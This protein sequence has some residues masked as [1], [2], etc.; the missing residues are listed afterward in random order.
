MTKT[1]NWVRLGQARH[2]RDGAGHPRGISSARRC[3]GRAARGRADRRRRRDKAIDAAVAAVAAR[4]GIAV[5]AL[6]GGAG[7]G[8]VDSAAL[9][10][11]AAKVTGRDGRAGVGGSMVL[12]QLGID[13]PVSALPATPTPN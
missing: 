10:E 5:A 1:W 3:T 7:G 11:F 6:A 13:A 9:D 8:V 2:R 4:R 12:G